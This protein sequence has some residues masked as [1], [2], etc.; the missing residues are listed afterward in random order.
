MGQRSGRGREGKGVEGK[1]RA[2]EWE[3]KG[4]RRGIARMV[5][6]DGHHYK[7]YMYEDVNLV[8]TYLI[9][10]QRYDKLWYK[11]VLR[12]IMQNK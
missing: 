10:K 12:I 1:G 11:G 3:G 8:S 9:Y 6:K 4:G 5:E 7:K 2:K